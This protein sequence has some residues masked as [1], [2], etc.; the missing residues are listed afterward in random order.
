MLGVE[1]VMNSSQSD[2]LV[3]AS[4][5]RNEMTLQQLVVI[6]TGCKRPTV[7]NII[8]VRSFQRTRL[9][10]EGVGVVRDVVQEGMAGAQRQR[11]ECVDRCRGCT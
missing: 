1:N 7:D 8:C 6:D 11:R 5:T 10:V 3:T 2:V 4:I 9:A